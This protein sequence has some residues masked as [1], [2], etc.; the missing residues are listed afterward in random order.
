VFKLPGSLSFDLSLVE[1]F[2]FVG[3]LFPANRMQIVL[4]AEHFL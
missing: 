3:A 4:T 2:D 1:L